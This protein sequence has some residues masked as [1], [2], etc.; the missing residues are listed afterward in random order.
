MD[1]INKIGFFSSMLVIAEV[2]CFAVLLIVELFGVKTG[3][4]SYAV[5]LL[6]APSILVMV[7]CINNL[8]D[9]EKKIWSNISAS[10]SVVYCVMC[11][12]NY[13][14]QLA[15]VKIY[16]FNFSLPVFQIFDFR[17]GSLFFTIDMLGY[18]FL[19]LSLFFLIPV[20]KKGKLQDVL[21]IFL[22]INGF[23][24][25]PTL[26]NPIFGLK[27]NQVTS[28][29]EAGNMILIG[30]CLI[31]IP[32][33]VILSMLFKRNGIGKINKLN[34]LFKKIIKKYGG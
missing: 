7:L 22:F 4:Y 12:M 34:Y 11:C 29:Y 19:C 32:I 18:A 16:N 26:L 24:F 27:Q 21:K 25:I 5:C 33:P 1:S 3:C 28:N 6:L 30:W 17:P 13:Y 20:F 23:L 2:F 10:F 9:P 14:V 15:F 8:S 31:F